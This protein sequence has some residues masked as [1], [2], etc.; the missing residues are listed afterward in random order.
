[1]TG[2]ITLFDG[3]Q[4]YIEFDI[5]N[6]LIM[7]VRPAGLE[8]WK[9]TRVLNAVFNI[10]GSLE[11]ALQWKDYDFP[12]KY[13]IVKIRKKRRFVPHKTI[14]KGIATATEA[15]SLIDLYGKFIAK[16]V[17][18]GDTVANIKDKTLAT[19]ESIVSE[20]ETKLSEDI[21]ESGDKYKIS[22]PQL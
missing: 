9:G 1:M 15:Y 17:E 4:D 22:R 21:I 20:Y 16:G 10:G 7:E 3:G 5:V 2:T 13:E 12:L 18:V 6:D 19:I 8:G 14:L 11:I